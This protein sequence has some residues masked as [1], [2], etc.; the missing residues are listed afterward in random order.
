MSLLSLKVYKTSS[1]LRKYFLGK[2]TQ[3]NL[4]N[5]QRKL[6][7]KRLS[8]RRRKCFEFTQIL[9]ISLKLTWETSWL[10]LQ[11]LTNFLNEAMSD[12]LEGESHSL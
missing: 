8:F 9:K 6:P 2:I 12:Y 4:F 1:V 3:L 11:I 7:G 5:Y 10:V